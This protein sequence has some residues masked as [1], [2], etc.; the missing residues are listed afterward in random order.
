MV[1]LNGINEGKY[2]VRPMDP[3]GM[4]V[5]KSMVVFGSRKRW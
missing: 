5:N 4:N 3:K 1:D 2:A